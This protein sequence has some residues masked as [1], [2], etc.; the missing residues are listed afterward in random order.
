MS[1]TIQIE[2][3]IEQVA[4][5]L[6]NEMGNDQDLAVFLVEVL[7]D[8]YRLDM[9]LDVV[10]NGIPNPVHELHSEYSTTAQHYDWDTKEYHDIEFCTLV[11]FNPAERGSEYRIKYHYDGKEYHTSVAE[12]KLTL[13]D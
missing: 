4:T 12:D 7:K 5:M 13:I 9:V 3:P 8:S 10:R 11:A 2:L 1:K 6:V